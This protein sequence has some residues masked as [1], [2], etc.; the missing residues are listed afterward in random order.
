MSTL[1]AIG[2]VQVAGGCA[3]LLLAWC[4]ETSPWTKV[5][6]AYACAALVADKPASAALR[7]DRVLDVLQEYASAPDP[8]LSTPSRRPP[9][10]NAG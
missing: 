5:M 2:L 4:L 3:V 1:T 10:R 8:G 7:L 9:L 6:V